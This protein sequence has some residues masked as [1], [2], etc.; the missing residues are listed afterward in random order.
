MKRR[1]LGILIMVA[2]AI[3]GVYFGIWEFLIKAIIDI[4][5]AVGTRFM[6]LKILYSLFKIMFG[7]WF[8][9]SIALF[10]FC[11]GLTIFKDNESKAKPSSE[12]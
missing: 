9:L 5:Y 3:G 4:V 7:S 10:I 12:S 8:T 11:Y 2:S 1:I 6:V